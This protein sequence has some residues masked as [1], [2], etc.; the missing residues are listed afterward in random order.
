MFPTHPSRVF[1]RFLVEVRTSRTLHVQCRETFSFEWFHFFQGLG[2]KARSSLLRD[3][4]TI[5]SLFKYVS[6]SCHAYYKYI[7]PRIWVEHRVPFVFAVTLYRDPL[8]EHVSNSRVC[9]RSY[10]LVA[11][12]DDD[13][14]LEQTQVIRDYGG[15][16]QNAGC[17]LSF[18]GLHL[19]PTIAHAIEEV[20][21]QAQQV[22]DLVL[23]DNNIGDAGAKVI[24]R[25]LKTNSTISSLNLVR[26][27]NACNSNAVEIANSVTK[28]SFVP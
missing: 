23:Y 20:L 13:A 25:A 8:L 28:T 4:I 12:F 16:V 18:G 3:F 11:F 27:F 1:S 7:T 14:I 19:G 17:C 5:N 26:G 22:R 10:L 24:A 21:P 6:Q 2:G 15:T 9:Y